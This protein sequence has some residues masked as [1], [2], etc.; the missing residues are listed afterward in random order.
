MNCNSILYFFFHKLY[1]EYISSDVLL[2]R[3]TWMNLDKRWFFF[4]LKNNDNHN[5]LFLPETLQRHLL[6][7]HRWIRRLWFIIWRAGSFI[8]IF[9]RLC[10]FENKSSVLSVSYFKVVIEEKLLPS[11]CYK[12]IDIYEYVRDDKFSLLTDWKWYWCNVKFSLVC[13]WKSV[14]FD[15]N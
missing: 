13:L 5:I 8:K 7:C 2:S 4:T 3:C 12:Q 1:L 6:K 10:P 14:T 11:S 9:T 15:I